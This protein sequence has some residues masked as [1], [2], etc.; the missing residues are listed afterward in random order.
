MCV[1]LR[2]VANEPFL[3]RRDKENLC[4]SIKMLFPNASLGRIKVDAFSPAS[5][6]LLRLIHETTY[7]DG[8]VNPSQTRKSFCLRLNNYTMKVE[9]LAWR[10][11][12]RIWFYFKMERRIQD[13]EVFIVYNDVENPN[14]DG[15]NRSSR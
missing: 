12:N 7:T 6:T 2:M 9:E 8:Y 10:P 15:I 1:V 3:L 13:F 14:H 4:S 11:R 5:N